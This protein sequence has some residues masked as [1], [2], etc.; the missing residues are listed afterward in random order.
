MLCPNQDRTR[1]LVDNTEELS[2]WMEKDNITDPEIE[3]WI[4]KYILMQ[5]NKPFFEMGYMCPKMRSLAKSQDLIRW[6][7]FTKGYISYEIQS[8]HLTMSSS[9]LNGADWTKLFI[10]KILPITNSSE[11]TAT[12]LSTINTMDISTRNNLKKY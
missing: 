12:S 1:L 6:Q 2:K 5:G 9:Y 11:S 7:N 8:F 10:S 3:Y 4:P